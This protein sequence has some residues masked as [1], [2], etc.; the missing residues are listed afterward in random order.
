MY[1]AVLEGLAFETKHNMLNL[2]QSGYRPEF[3]A[4]TGGGA[5]SALLMQIK[6]DVLNCSI[7]IPQSA[8]SGI[9]GLAMICAVAMGEYNNYREAAG[10]CI[11]IK[12]TFFPHTDYGVRC[13]NYIT[14]NRTIKQL[15][16]IL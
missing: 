16:D 14:I 7:N 9:V 13:N 12:K 4:A 6:A 8:D 1:R 2:E 15:Y 5:K 3:F 10:R 11:Q